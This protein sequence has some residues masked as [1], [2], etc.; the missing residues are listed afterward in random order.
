M[1]AVDPLLHRAIERQAAATGDAP[2]VRAGGAQLT[3]RELETQANR[4]AWRLRSFGVGRDVPVALLLERSLELAIG[5]VGTL[6]AG[7]GCLPLDVHEVPDRLARIVARCRPGA[8]LTHARYRE[9]FASL[10]LPTCAVDDDGD[11]WQREPSH[12][13]DAAG[14]PEDLAFVFAT[15]GSSGLPKAV[16]LP[17]RACAAGL[18]WAVDE[19]GMG[20]GDRHLLKTAVNYASLLRQLIW[21]L[22]SGGAAILV[23][24]GADMDVRGM[25]RLIAEEGVSILIFIPSLLDAF[26]EE[27]GWRDCRSL[28]HVLC[29]AEPLRQQLRERL[30]G[31][32]DCSIYNLYA[33]TEAPLV[34][35]WRCSPGDRDVAPI[36]EP[37]PGIRWWVLDDHLRPAAPGEPG[38]LCLEGPGVSRGYLGAPELTAERYVANPFSETPGAVLYRTGDH[39]RFREDGELEYAGRVDRLVKIRGFRIDLGEVETA[40]ARHPCVA[41]AVVVAAPG[42]LGSRRIVAW[43]VPRAGTAAEAA[44][45]VAFVAGKLPPFMHPD[46]VRF[47]GELPRTTT[48]KIDR[49]GLVAMSGLAPEPAGPE[50]PAG[51]RAARVRRLVAELLEVAE[52]GEEDDFFALGGHSL[53]MVRLLARMREEFGVDIVA[54]E[55]FDRPTVAMLIERATEAAA[56]R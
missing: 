1:T 10:G 20:P 19:F 39:V 49:Q 3:Y 47:V 42:R 35:T 46:E 17:H 7:A 45:L 52:V 50:A 6:K 5:V 28:R 36:G 51:S 25:T 38:E 26:L 44:G 23:P 27:P 8:V 22:V 34:G 32:V 56:G 40:L 55:F 48:G 2:A 12:A 41:T 11:A 53:A 37:V 15:S 14:D 18:G 16:M 4:L 33:Q 29:G 13:P 54:D 9:R 30:W 24:P 31:I 21:P 43:V